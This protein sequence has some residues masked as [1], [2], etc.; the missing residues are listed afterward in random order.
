MLQLE[1]GLGVEEVVLALATPLV[2]AADGELAVR[3]LA[4]AL[5]V[6]ELVPAR[7]LAG[8]DVEVDALDPRRGAGEVLVDEAL[9]QPDG[10]ED[11]GA[12]VGGD[13]G[14]AHLRHHL[15]D[16]LA[17]GLDVVL[18]GLALGQVGEHALAAQVADRVEREV[19]VDATRAVAEQ[20]REVMHLARLT[21]LDEQPDTRPGLLPHE[22]VMHGRG[23]AGHKLVDTDGSVIALIGI[24]LITTLAAWLTAGKPRST[25]LVGAGS[26]GT[27]AAPGRSNFGGLAMLWA[28]V[29]VAGIGLVVYQLGPLLQQREQHDL[30]SE[31]RTEIRHAANS[32]SGIASTGGVAKAPADG[33]PVGVL[34]VGSLQTQAV[35]VEGVT[36]TET[37]K[38]PGHVPGTAGLGQPGNAAVVARRNG[39]GGAFADLSQ[40]RKGDRILVTT[41][42]GQSVYVVRTTKTESISDPPDDSSGS[43]A[44]STAGVDLVVE[45]RRRPLRRRPLR[46]ERRR[47]PHA[48]D[49]G[50]PHALEHGRRDRRDREDAGPTV[51][52]HTAERTVRRR[53]RS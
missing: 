11:L 48:G 49:V 12:G 24:V 8:D 10:L 18:D 4:R 25:A 46:S 42:Q 20:E 39:Y 52:A 32:G 26:S 2:L 3:E 35:V 29:A 31:Y 45:G 36:P 21:R 1:H 43:S 13:G 6:R 30:L 17:R 41:T 7:D 33:D 27:T 28:G 22:V 38:G 44:T 15:E 23:D 47:P 53:D 16:A 37:R 40:V 34:E 14:D 50:E 9:L 51:R 19:G 5:G